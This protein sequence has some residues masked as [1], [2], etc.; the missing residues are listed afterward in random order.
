VAK[1]LTGT[2]RAWPRTPPVK[3]DTEREGKREGGRERT[4]EKGREGDVNNKKEG[5]RVDVMALT[6]RPVLGL[7]ISARQ[8]VQTKDFPCGE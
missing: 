2:I 5:K 4:G 3:T 1:F 7:K 6:A 8:R